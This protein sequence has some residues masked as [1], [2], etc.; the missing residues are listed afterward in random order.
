MRI[1]KYNEKPFHSEGSDVFLVEYK[2]MSDIAHIYDCFLKVEGKI[3]TDT[4]KEV[5]NSMFFCLSGNRFNGNIYAEKALE[6]GAQYVVTTESGKPEFL[7][8]ENPN[9]TLLALSKYHSSKSNTKLIAVG[10]SNGKTTTKELINAVLD[11]S[12]SHRSTPGNFNNHIGVPL[13]LLSIDSSLDLGT[14]E[15]GTN[16]PGEMSILCGLFR[17]DSGLITNIG[18]E[19]LEG[20]KDIEAIAREESEVFLMLHR[21]NGTAMINLDDPWI[22]NMSKR[23]S[24]TLT[25]SLTDPKANLFLE[26]LE[27]MPTLKFKA[28]YKQTELGSFEANLGGRYNGYNIAA[29]SILG[30][31]YG[32]GA[33]IAIQ[34]CCEYQSNNNRSQWLENDRSQKIFLDAY[35]ANPSSMTVGLESFSTIQ[36]SKTLLL[37]DMLEMGSHSTTEHIAVFDKAKELGYEDIFLVGGEFKKALPSY[38]FTFDD[39]DGLLAWL[40]T[41]PIESQF[42]FIKGSRGIAMERSLEHFDITLN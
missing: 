39:V 20:F 12:F 22:E 6:L 3:A 27:E 13:T 4:R 31:N 36:G 11:P 38:P 34:R 18:K 24:N 7:T 10:G 40:D 30:I 29:A 14:I 19:H 35:N 8:V 2:E 25:Y 37:G 28:F 23:L 41:H 33:T 15:L 16:H 1:T 9:E 17:A 42:I 32:I 5:K 21:D 26:I